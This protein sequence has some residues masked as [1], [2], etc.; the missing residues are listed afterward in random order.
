MKSVIEFVV[1][2][3]VAHGNLLAETLPFTMYA[4]ISFNS[5]CKITKT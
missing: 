5:V 4:D 3:R 1:P 2:Q